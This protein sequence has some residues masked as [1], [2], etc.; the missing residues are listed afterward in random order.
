MI[1]STSFCLFSSPSDCFWLRADEEKSGMIGS[2]PTPTSGV[3]VN[4]KDAAESS[5]AEVEQSL[6]RHRQAH[7]SPVRLHQLPSSLSC[8]SCPN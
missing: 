7:A 8:Q 1:I 6:G 4:Q 5:K 2:L 3:G